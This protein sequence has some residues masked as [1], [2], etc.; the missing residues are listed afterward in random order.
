MGHSFTH[1]NIISTI[2]LLE[3]PLL[4]TY[5]W[6]SHFDLMNHRELFVNSL[7]S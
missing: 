2:I 1:L 7:M 3:Q 4:F 6:I 5:K